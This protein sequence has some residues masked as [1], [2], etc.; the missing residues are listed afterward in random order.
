MDSLEKLGQD[1]NKVL[2]PRLLSKSGIE[3]ILKRLDTKK[4]FVLEEVGKGATIQQD[5]YN[6]DLKYLESAGLVKQDN[7]IYTLTDNGKLVAKRYEQMQEFEESIKQRNKP[8]RNF[9]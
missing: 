5:V 2:K 6:A 4:K 9:M 8:R 3:N 7:T 1:L